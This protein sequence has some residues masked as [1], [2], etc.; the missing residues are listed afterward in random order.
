MR[1]GRFTRATFIRAAAA[2]VVAA[3]GVWLT[4]ACT[5]TSGPVPAASP[6]FDL[7][8]LPTAPPAPRSAACGRLSLA[9]ASGAW[10]TDWLD[11]P[12][13]PS[14][15][16]EQAR[17]LPLLDFFWLGLGPGPETIRQHPHNPAAESLRSVLRTA[18]SAN[19]CG[20]RF[21]TIADQRTPK[22]T[23]ARMLLDPGTRWHHVAALA[24]G[25]A[26]YPQADGLTLD[27]E[28]ALPSSQRDLDLYASVAGWHGLTARQEVARITAGYTGLV[29]ELALAMHRQ[30]R[31]LRVAVKPRVT[32][33]IDLA[34]PA[35]LLYDYGE[36]AKYADQLVLMAIDFHWARSDPGPIAT[37]AD[38]ENVLARVRAY[39]IPD[40]QLAV[41]LAAYGYDWTVDEA[42]HRLPGTEATSVTA[43]SI[44]RQHWTMAGSR[45]GESYY[46]YTARGHHHVVWF[47]GHALK[48]RAASLERL[49]P[50]I[51]V[52]VWAAGNT[53]PTGSA[54]IMQAVPPKGPPGSG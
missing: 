54:L 44:A 32:G 34:D 24:A 8:T 31:T 42:G 5:G 45:D 23:M 12:G 38:I 21:V 49:Y 6:G 9:G 47:A 35:P 40:A 48:S 50:G 26:R 53:D 29:R 46:E 51:A 16:P 18:A 25:M 11:Q 22:A 4:A 52:V 15:L 1:S 19:P 36:L 37:M 10:L 20:L 30:H 28:Y 3:S 41:E 7:R 27:Y 17:R 13:R 43:T 14:V 33:G 2:A 39:Q